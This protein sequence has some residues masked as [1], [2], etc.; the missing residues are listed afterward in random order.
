[1]VVGLLLGFHHKDSHI[2]RAG[3]VVKLPKKVSEFW[4]DMIL[5]INDGIFMLAPL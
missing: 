4:N 5:L 1:M 2:H 3:M